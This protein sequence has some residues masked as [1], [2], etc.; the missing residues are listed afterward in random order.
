[1]STSICSNSGPNFGSI[2]QSMLANEEAM[3]ETYKR[4]QNKSKQMLIESNRRLKEMV[5]STIEYNE[6]QIREEICVYE[7]KVCEIKRSLCM[8]TIK[9]IVDK[10]IENVLNENLPQ[11]K[12]D[13]DKMIKDYFRE[14]VSDHEYF[15]TTLKKSFEKMIETK[16][17]ELKYV[18]QTYKKNIREMYD[19]TMY[20][21]KEYKSEGPDVLVLEKKPWNNE[22][23][24]IEDLK[25]SVDRLEGLVHNKL[26][27]S[28]GF[29]ETT[30]ERFNKE[31]KAVKETIEETKALDEK[32]LE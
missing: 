21:L 24:L 18:D 5:Q 19:D 20:T 14:K 4:N 3:I 7:S 23:Q 22:I 10:T 17:S 8:N 2:Y 25:L 15:K 32:I 11:L 30:A 27:E 26:K 28:K 29:L 12:I 6:Q 9:T 16:E 13:G 31:L 1:M